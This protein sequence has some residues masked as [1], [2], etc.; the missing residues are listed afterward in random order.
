MSCPAL[1]KRRCTHFT[2]FFVFTSI[3]DTSCSYVWHE[4]LLLLLSYSPPVPACCVI[5]AHYWRHTTLVLCRSLV[6]VENS[7]RFHNKSTKRITC[8]PKPAGFHW[9]D[10]YT[11]VTYNYK[12][13]LYCNTHLSFPALTRWEALC[14]CYNIFLVF[15]WKPNEWENTRSFHH[16]VVFSRFSEIEKNISLFTFSLK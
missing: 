1:K 11:H 2:L 16:I 14:F 8:K 3:V 5:L 6:V 15:S 10:T 13:P 12:G 4:Q 7:I 9:S